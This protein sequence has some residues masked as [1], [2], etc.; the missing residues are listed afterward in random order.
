MTFKLK[1]KQP[2]PAA[3]GRPRLLAALAFP[4]DF[5][6]PS[7]G[8]KNLSV[9]GEAQSGRTESERAD[10]EVRYSR[11]RLQGLR[12]RKE[13]AGDRQGRRV[14]RPTTGERNRRCKGGP[15]WK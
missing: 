13:G 1:L 11:Y 15:A 14:R 8:E 12:G 10:R 7:I 9:T 5:G 6:L 2:S 3:P 4:R